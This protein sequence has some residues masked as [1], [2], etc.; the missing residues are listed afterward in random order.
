MAIILVGI[1]EKGHGCYAM[2]LIQSI[3]IKQVYPATTPLFLV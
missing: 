1:V 2:P 3:R